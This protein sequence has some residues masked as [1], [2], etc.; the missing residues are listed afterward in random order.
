MCEQWRKRPAL[1]FYHYYDP[2]TV[3]HDTGALL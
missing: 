3:D 2:D 1:V